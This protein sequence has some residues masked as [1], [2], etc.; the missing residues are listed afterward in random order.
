MVDLEFD[1]RFMMGVEN[2][3]PFLLGF[4]FGE[5]AALAHKG[6]SERLL[7]WC[8]AMDDW[9]ADRHQLNR[10]STYRNSKNAWRY[11]LSRCCLLYTSPS[12]RDR[13]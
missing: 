11:M 3:V 7:R 12:P 6:A 2:E 8:Q 9:L 10:R 13:S 4:M 1:W 5:S